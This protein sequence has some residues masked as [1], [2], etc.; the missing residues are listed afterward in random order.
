M[1]ATIVD[2]QLFFGPKLLTAREAI[3]SLYADAGQLA[4]T[5]EDLRRT[6]FAH[7]RQLE[8]AALAGEPLDNIRR[9]LAQVRHELAEIEREHTGLLTEARNITIEETRHAANQIAEQERQAIAAL[10]RPFETVILEAQQ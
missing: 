6:E 10:I 5:L 3:E 2:G 9:T 7:Q 1:K 8:E 4:G